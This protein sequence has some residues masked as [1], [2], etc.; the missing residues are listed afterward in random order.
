VTRG[1][2]SVL[3]VERELAVAA[4][5]AATLR[6]RGHAVSAVT[7]AEEALRLPVP[8]VI[9]AALELDGLDGLELLELLRRDGHAVRTV[10]MTSLPS[11][12]DCRR[13]LR[14]GA[15]EFL[16][17]PFDADELVPAVEGSSPL[18][19]LPAD[20]DPLSFRCVFSALVEEAELGVRDLTAQ[21][22][23]W[24]LGPT[25][26]ARVA[27]AAVEVLD[28]AVRHAYPLEP[29]KL[30]IEAQ[31]DGRE[32]VVRI[33]DRGLGFDASGQAAGAPHDPARSG[34]A[35]ACAL[36][37]ALRIETAPGAGTTVELRFAAYRSS[38]D[39]HG[40]IDLSELDWL[41]PGMSRRVLEILR[42]EG[43]EGTFHLSPAMAVTVGRILTGAPAAASAQEAL[44]S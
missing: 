2:L 15:A 28:N 8:D 37:E 34:L 23:R 24:G 27:T 41:T 44:W 39:E 29:G 40:A 4:A 14:L 9:V 35:R 33:R 25:V 7:R 31:C 12:R 43:A 1:S 19:P 16:A 32:V 22:V 18:A 20:P 30:Q 26:R 10:L 6:R 36:S 21:L 3:V 42:A 17:K 11:L 5:V 38:F 13:A